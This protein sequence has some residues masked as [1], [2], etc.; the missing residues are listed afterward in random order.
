MLKVISR[1][2][3]KE[4]LVFLVAAFVLADP[5]LEIA[6]R[7]EWRPY[8]DKEVDSPIHFAIVIE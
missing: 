1:L 6:R 8:V 3:W 4:W 5:Y 7:G 2:T